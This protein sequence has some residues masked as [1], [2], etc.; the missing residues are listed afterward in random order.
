MSSRRL[1]GG[2]YSLQDFESIW[3]AND[4]AMKTVDGSCRSPMNVIARAFSPHALHGAGKSFRDITAEEL[5]RLRLIVYI[6]S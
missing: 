6:Y 3:N 4:P 5:A 2:R 1:T